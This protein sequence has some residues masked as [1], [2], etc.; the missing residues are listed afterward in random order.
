MA[1]WNTLWWF[2][3]EIYVGKHFSQNFSLEIRGSFKIRLGIDSHPRWSVTI[4][5]SGFSVKAGEK[6][7]TY[8]SRKFDQIRQAIEKWTFVLCKRHSSNSLKYNF[9]RFRSKIIVPIVHIS[10]RCCI[11]LH[12]II[13]DCRYNFHFI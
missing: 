11:K 9:A 13:K 12:K 8:C 1:L 5:S 2:D 7:I 4:L 3:S 10:S 6:C